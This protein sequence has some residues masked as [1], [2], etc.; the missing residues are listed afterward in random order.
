MSINQKLKGILVNEKLL[1]QPGI[2][3]ALDEILSKKADADIKEAFFKHKNIWELVDS[4]L[5]LKADEIDIG[6]KTISMLDLKNLAAHARIRFHLNNSTPS[7]LEN[8]IAASDNHKAVRKI[9]VKAPWTNGLGDDDATKDQFPDEFLKVILNTAK[10]KYLI[11]KIKARKDSNTLALIQNAHTEDA[12]KEA[13]VAIGIP[14]IAAK[15]DM[16][17]LTKDDKGFIS[18][19]YYLN[20]LVES[21]AISPLQA[22]L[23]RIANAENLENLDSLNLKIMEGHKF[24]KL[25]KQLLQ[26]HTQRIIQAAVTQVL[27]LKIQE[28]NDIQLLETLSAIDTPTT[29][30]E[31]LKTQKSLG[32][33]GPGNNSLRSQVT[34]EIV[35]TTAV[36]ARVRK[37]LRFGT[38]AQVEA[39]LADN[40]LDSFSERYNQVFSA[41][42]D[43]KAITDR[44]F[45][46]EENVL[47]AQQAAFDCFVKLRLSSMS[48]QE[49]E[50]IEQKTL[51]SSLGLPQLQIDLQYFYLCFAT[52][53][54]LRK[55]AQPDISLENVVAY[56]EDNRNDNWNEHKLLPKADLQDLKVDLV[57]IIVNKIGLDKAPSLILLAQAKDHKAF[58]VQLTAMGINEHDWITDASVQEI[59]KVASDRVL[60]LKT[61]N[62]P[63][64]QKILGNLPEDKKSQLLLT[65]NDPVIKNLQSQTNPDAIAKILG[66][67]KE[68]LGYEIVP[69]KRPDIME[70]G[71]L[72]VEFDD[73][74]DNKALLVHHTAGV[75]PIRL[76]EAAL[77]YSL[78]M[79][80]KPLKMDQLKA[81]APDILMAAAGVKRSLAHDLVRENEQ[82]ALI[83]RIP[84]AELVKAIK[85]AG[86]TGVINENSLEELIKH[87]NQADAPFFITEDHEYEDFDTTKK[88]L[89]D[90]F[91]AAIANVISIRLDDSDDDS[92]ADQMTYNEKLLEN[93]VKSENAFCDFMLPL[94]K[95][96]EFA[97]DLITPFLS[98]VSNA[99]SKEALIAEIKNNPSLLG[100]DE[101][102]IAAFE[103]QLTTS[104]FLKLQVAAK[105]A[106]YIRDFP[107]QHKALK[108]EVEKLST[109]FTDLTNEN[110]F[111]KQ[112]LLK[113]ATLQNMDFI[114][115]TFQAASYENAISMEQ[116]LADLDRMSQIMLA[117]CQSQL[118]AVQRLKDVLPTDE[119]NEALYDDQSSIPYKVAGQREKLTN[120]ENYINTVKAYYER[121]ALRLHGDP[122]VSITDKGIKDL[123]DP[124]ASVRLIKRGMLDVVKEAKA[125]KSQICLLDADFADILDY[126]DTPENRAQHREATYTGDLPQQLQGND[127]AQMQSRGESRKYTTLP[128]LQEGKRREHI[129]YYK[130]ESST[131]VFG[132]ISYTDTGIGIA[133][134]GDQKGQVIMGRTTVADKWP[135]DLNRKGRTLTA[136]TDAE[137]EYA[138]NMCNLH[139]TAFNTDPTKK[140]PVYLNKGTKREIGVL[141]TV[142]QFMGVE[143]EAIALP[144]GCYF[145]PDEQK[146]GFFNRFTD[147]SVYKQI[148]K[149]PIIQDLKKGLDQVRADTKLS[150]ERAKDVKENLGAVGSDL[151][152]RL[153]EAKEGK[154]PMEKAEEEYKKNSPGLSG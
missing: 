25:D 71:K 73:T 147:E 112:R 12:F 18:Q 89:K 19:L 58:K 32:L 128:P 59:Q 107:A 38:L 104:Q 140:Q 80:K 102:L 116:D 109:E 30:Q 26:D 22:D 124:E 99:E 11:D 144:A 131:S 150:Q 83:D 85:A 60:L 96:E 92:F 139:L 7:E 84:N 35:K 10:H 115:P 134:S 46:N 98:E 16:K 33:N 31:Q 120:L 37:N 105:K 64:L 149:K 110:Y 67:D 61:G 62:A 4:S 90:T 76:N 63:Q 141:W 79:M 69:G 14:S 145:K 133:A 117:K 42:A 142:M 48:L 40:N 56:M 121:I 47:S 94:Q 135:G 153:K 70:E 127:P 55:L 3:A 45:L 49:L 75:A 21:I 77:R 44:Y 36:I 103:K 97:D 39:I 15:L 82:L 1:S 34:P 24:E 122:N 52:Q 20:L 143:A 43:T 108:T 50:T 93:D 106:A 101:T 123:P 91:G 126:D 66:V 114:N 28:C 118:D 119:E 148:E 51:Y 29:L 6:D 130:S 65:K 132:S 129:K 57:K 41:G 151:K 137:V 5:Q 136:I 68:L 111:F 78:R 13:C 152:G 88:L 8:I 17:L 81:F 54:S 138:V 9:L 27:N 95:S 154:S 146:G 2:Q 125:G 23:H 87:L 86:I 53:K 72:Y 100:N 113:A 74:S